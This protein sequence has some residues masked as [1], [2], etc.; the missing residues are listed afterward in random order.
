MGGV[1][2]VPQYPDIF[3]FK[4]KKN[5]IHSIKMEQTQNFGVIIIALIFI[6]VVTWWW[7]WWCAC[8]D[9]EY[10][11]DVVEFLTKQQTFELLKADED[12]FYKTFFKADLHARHVGSV[13]EYIDLIRDRG[14]ADFTEEEKIKVQKAIELSNIFLE[15]TKLPWFDGKKAKSDKWRVAKTTIFYEDGLP[16]TRGTSVIILSTKNLNDDLQTLSTTLTHEKIH[17]YQKKYPLEVAAYL[18]LHGF[19]KVKE[20]EEQDLIRANPDTDNYRYTTHDGV[21]LKTQYTSAYP[22]SIHDVIVSNQFYEH[23]FERM[24]LEILE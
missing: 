1:G 20:R 17:L 21:E 7:R 11:E 23:P 18:S 2:V 22:N 9:E 13:D 14:V 16:H 15:K 5:L 3:L 8:K 12:G 4:V 6:V 10:Y 24:V 19:R